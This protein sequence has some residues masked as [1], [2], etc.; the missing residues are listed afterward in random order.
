M[1][2]ALQS[3]LTLIL[4]QTEKSGLTLIDEIEIPYGIKLLFARSGDEI[5]LN[6]YYSDKKGISSVIGGK[7]QN[8][9]K[10]VLNEI[11]NKVMN[12][13]RAEHNWE[14]WVGTD[15][16]GKGDLFGP[17]VVCGFVMF[18]EDREKLFRMGIKDSKL[19]SDKR[20][21]ELVPEIQ[22]KFRGRYEILSLTPLKYNQLYGQFR[23]QGKKLNELLA[24][25]HGR[26]ILNLADKFPVEGSVIDRFASESTIR[27]SLRDL[28]MKELIVIE[29]AEQSDLAVATASLLARNFFLGKMLDLNR[30]FGL[31]FVRGSGEPAK[32]LLQTFISRIGKD[33]LPEVAKTHF[34]PV[35]TLLEK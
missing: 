11:L 6:L 23:A 4:E 13:H 2:Q 15:E 19:L 24:W 30:K 5:P 17:L 35:S 3:A 9:L 29:R 14:V 34:K 12:D 21:T 7:Q 22:R 26:I 27:S 25:M 18:R 16:S 33:R 28:K 1:I 32:M 31:D 10:L 8:P 20:I